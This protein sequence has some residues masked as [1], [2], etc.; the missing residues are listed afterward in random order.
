MLSVLQSLTHVKTP[1]D[2]LDFSP[3][4]TSVHGILQTS[5]LPFPSLGDLPNPGIKPVSPVSSALQADS[6]PAEL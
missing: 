6:L 3:P 2:R 1:C 5:G 4:G